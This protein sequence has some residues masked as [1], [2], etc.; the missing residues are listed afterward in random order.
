MHKC[1]APPHAKAIEDIFMG[2]LKKFEYRLGTKLG[3][4]C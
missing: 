1:T 3:N 4:Y 2:Q